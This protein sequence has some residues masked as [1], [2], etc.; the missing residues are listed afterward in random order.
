GL[1]ARLR[2][3]T[4][5]R[6]ARREDGTHDVLVPGAAAQVAG[7]PL[8]NLRLARVGVLAQQVDRGH[9][10]ARGAE[11]A[12]ERVLLVERPLHRVQRAVRPGQALERGDLRAPGPPG[13]YRGALHADRPLRAARPAAPRP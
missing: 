11:P 1:A 12:L 5:H 7:Q 10:H 3:R 6:R 13:P 2:T 8:P 9:D 4:A